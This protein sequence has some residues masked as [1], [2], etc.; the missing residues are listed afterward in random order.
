MSVI[1]MDGFDHYGAGGDTA[2]TNMLS[3]PWASFPGTLDPSIGVPNFGPART[4]PYCLIGTGRGTGWNRRILPSTKTRIFASFGFAIDSIPSSDSNINGIFAIM[5]GSNNVINYLRITTTGALSICQSDGT[6][7]ATTSGPV[8][9]ASTWHFL[10]MDINTA[11]NWTVRLD[12]PLASE[13]PILIGALS[14]GTIASIAVLNMRESTTTPNTPTP[15]MDD[16]IVRDTSG[17]IN[18]GWLGDRRVA[19]LFADEDTTTAGWTPSYYR[20]VSPGIGRFS[21]TIAG[22]STVQSNQARITTAGAVA[23]DVGSGDFT[24]ETF[25]RF[26]RLP[27]TTE[28]Y[29]IFSRWNENSVTG[30]SFRLVYGGPSY[31]G[32]NLEFQTSTDGSGSTAQVK[33]SYPWTPEADRW[34]HVALCRDSGELLLFIDGIQM[35]LPIVDSDTYFGGASGVFAVGGYV[36]SNNTGTSATVGTT[37][38]GRMDE[39]RFTNGVSRYNS[40]FTPTTTLFPRGSSDPDWSSV[41]LLMGYDSGINDESSFNRTLN[42]SGVTSQLPAD[43]ASVGAWSTVGSTK[44]DPDDNTF[45]SASLLN[46][47]NILTMTT[48]PS[49]SDTIT[50]GTTNGTTPAVYKFVSSLVDPFDVLIGTDADETLDNLVAAINGDAGEGTTYGTGTTS[51]VDVNAVTLVS[52][53]IQ[54][55]ANIAGAVGNSVAVGS[56]S[57]GVW[58]DPANLYGGQDIPG[59]SIF[60]FQRPPSNTTI[61]S[62]VQINVRAQKTDAGTGAIQTSL[63]GPLGGT[64]DGAIHS[65]TLNPIYY[66]D[67]IEEDPDTSGPLSPTTIINGGIKINRTS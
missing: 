26:D 19:T 10:E 3:G 13:S 38:I 36:G 22:T 53:Q 14:G 37:L 61:I 12:D 49:A 27:E 43:G 31:N 52:G 40:N 48:N 47:T 51:N 16:L 21:Y 59:P 56:S 30:R 63:V 67:V 45:V 33:V 54:V 8:I 55:F 23:L 20:E 58:E 4:G 2:M 46:A 25:V 62:A 34:Y 44:A 6:V 50:V 60:K 64:T 39:T 24:L 57:P 1:F 15:Y 42:T 32:G 41:V 11:G 7:I 66:G 9:T 5:D 35:G 65:L 29:T 28:Y 18:D 17:G